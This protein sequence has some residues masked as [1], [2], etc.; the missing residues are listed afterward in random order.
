[1]A[2]LDASV[3]D[4]PVL[5]A[6]PGS[7]WWPLLWG[8]VFAVV[9]VLVEVL[10]RG[11]VHV[12]TWVVLTGVLVASTAVWVYGRRRVCSLRLT[13]TALSL[14]REVVPVDAIS[15]VTDVGGPVGAPVLG[16]GWTVPKGTTEVPL[17]LDRALRPEDPPQGRVVLGWA[18]DPEA[19]TSALRSLLDRR[20]ERA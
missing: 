6:E 2:D 7:S 19:L 16:G 9:G 10:T 15:A 1:M 8:P 17:R 18:R 13:P 12:L 20:D 11:P 3:A 4:G 14:G 5:Y